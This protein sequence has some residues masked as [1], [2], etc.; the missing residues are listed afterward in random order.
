MVKISE[1]IFNNHYKM[2]VLISIIQ[3]HHVK[4]IKGLKQL[5]AEP[6]DPFKEDDQCLVTIPM[7]NTH[8][9]SYYPTQWFYE[10]R[11][12]LAAKK[13]GHNNVYNS[14][15]GILLKLYKLGFIKK[16]EKKYY[17]NTFNLFLCKN[18]SEFR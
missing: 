18:G 17:K 8:N 10:L 3:Q 11:K 9:F 6:E 12:L 7:N 2:A 16:R 14:V 1:A 4:Y 5:K 13:S 15:N